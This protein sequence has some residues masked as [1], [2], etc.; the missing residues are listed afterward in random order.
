MAKRSPRKVSLS[1]RAVKDLKIEL[2]KQVLV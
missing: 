1:T 2:A